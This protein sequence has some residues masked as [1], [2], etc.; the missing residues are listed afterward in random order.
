[1]SDASRIERDGDDWVHIDNSTGEVLERFSFDYGNSP[2]KFLPWKDYDA[3]ESKEECLR[4]SAFT[5]LPYGY[6][7]VYRDNATGLMVM[8][9]NRELT[10]EQENLVR[11]KEKEDL[12][13]LTELKAAVAKHSQPSVYTLN[14]V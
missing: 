10:E 8:R 1:M 5:L 14:S 4:V 3:E 9:R 11:Q 12:A 6:K 13:Y 7:P 2:F